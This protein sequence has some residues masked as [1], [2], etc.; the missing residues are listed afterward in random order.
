[1]DPRNDVGPEISEYMRQQGTMPWKL[2]I[3]LTMAAAQSVRRTLD[4]YQTPNCR[5]PAPA[6]LVFKAMQEAALQ[7]ADAALRNK[8]AASRFLTNTLRA[9]HEDPNA[10]YRTCAHQGARGALVETRADFTARYGFAV[11][12]D[13][14]ISQLATHI[15]GREIL[16][17]GA[18]NGY[19]AH[20]LAQAGVSILPTDANPPQQSGYPLGKVQ[21]TD[22]IN[23]EA[24]T[25]I[26]ELPE[27]DLLWSWPCPDDSSGQALQHFQGKTLIYIGEQDDGCTAGKLFNQMLAQRFEPVDFIDIPSFPG[28][29]DCVGIYR[30]R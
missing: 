4:D 7:G 16:E 23:I 1:M 26:R 18:G 24:C 6:H 30:R 21:Y 5:E 2:S 13:D 12:T 11:I 19:L 20:R 10:W 3:F 28:V 29:H 8:V 25:A 27:M 17:V 22:I 9:S 15:G 14:A